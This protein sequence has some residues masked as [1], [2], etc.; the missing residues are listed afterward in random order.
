[1]YGARG[2]VP[3]AIPGGFLGGFDEAVLVALV[4]WS[5]IELVL[6]GILRIVGGRPGA[7]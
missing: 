3:G 4:G 1:M 6:F 5:L 2:G 7:S